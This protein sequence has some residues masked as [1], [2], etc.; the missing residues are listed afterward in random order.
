M[1]ISTFENVMYEAGYLRGKLGWKP[2]LTPAQE[3][4]RYAWALQHN[5]DKNEVGDGLRYNF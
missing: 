2:T 4:E 5:P 1:T 3:K